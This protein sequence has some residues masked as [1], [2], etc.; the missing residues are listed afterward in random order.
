[1]CVKTTVLMREILEVSGGK[2]LFDGLKTVVDVGGGVGAVIKSV[3]S[4]YPGI[5]GINFDLPHVIKNAPKYP[6]IIYIYIYISATET[7]LET[8]YKSG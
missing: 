8:M 3:V 4:K 7:H 1:M 2:G 5:R 6:G